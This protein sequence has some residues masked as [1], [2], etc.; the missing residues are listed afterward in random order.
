MR[1]ADV[2]GQRFE[3]LH[4]F[5]GEEVAV[6]RAAQADDGDGA[7]HRPVLHAAGK[8]VVQVEQRGGAAFVL[9]QVQ[10]LLRILEEDMRVA[11]RLRR[12]RGSPTPAR[13]GSRSGRG[14]CAPPMGRPCDAARRSR[15][16]SSARKTAT[17]RY[18]QRPR[19]ALDDRI[20][21]GT[22]IG[23]RIQA[24][25]ELDQRLAVVVT[26][27]VEDA[28]DPALD[29]PLQRFEDRSHHQDR[30]AEAPL[31]DRL[32]QAWCGPFRLITAI[33]AEVDA[34]DQRPVASV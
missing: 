15:P 16:L 30:D 22:E 29:P 21:Q 3:Q 34:Q 23:L 17:A 26:L 6:D 14:P 2:A 10:R 31:A 12:S 33:D 11:A 18:E 24:A 9:R 5:A 27:P 28:I 7:R 19:Q 13:P 4:V 32:R 20:E 8:V 25:A 1:D